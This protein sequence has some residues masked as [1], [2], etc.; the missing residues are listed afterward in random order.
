MLSY[1]RSRG[2]GKIR[3]GGEG[4]EK[5]KSKRLPSKAPE[6]SNKLCLAALSSSSFFLLFERHLVGFISVRVLGK[7]FRVIELG[8]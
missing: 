1:K 6:T 7:A 8:R 5:K 3:C 2:V 4:M